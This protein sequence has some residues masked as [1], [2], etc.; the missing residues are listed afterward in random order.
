MFKTTRVAKKLYALR[1]ERR[2]QPAGPASPPHRGGTCPMHRGHAQLNQIYAASSK[3]HA[4][5][6]IAP[7]EEARVH[8]SGQ[9]P[10]AM[11]KV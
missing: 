3:E 1:H 4:T 8:G 7:S 10:C 9:V 5:Q 6:S 11:T 2:T